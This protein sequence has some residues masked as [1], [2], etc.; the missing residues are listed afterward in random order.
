MNPLWLFR[1]SQ[2]ARNPP[3][4]KRVRLVAIVIG[5]VLIIAGLEYF[6]LWPEA[7]TADR[8]RP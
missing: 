3:S 7:L 8:L 5:T 4:A 2:W 1:M 6:G